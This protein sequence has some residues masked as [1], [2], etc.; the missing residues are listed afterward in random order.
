MTFENQ[1]TYRRK[2]ETVRAARLT[3]EGNIAI[4]YNWIEKLIAERRLVHTDRG[5]WVQHPRGGYT[6]HTQALY[7]GDWI[8]LHDGS[9]A[10]EVWNDERFQSMFDGYDVEEDV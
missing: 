7:P 6:S 4:K 1:V 8:V 9:G 2:P 5:W 10:L 3:A